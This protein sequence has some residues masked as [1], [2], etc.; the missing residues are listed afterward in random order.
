MRR[1]EK[2]R[3]EEGDYDKMKTNKERKG[4]GRKRYIRWCREGV[5][6]I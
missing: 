4:K 5:M 6:G 2:D 3:R 1:E